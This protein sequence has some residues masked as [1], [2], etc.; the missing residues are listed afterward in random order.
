[1]DCDRCGY[2]V[3]Q[4]A[5]RSR[6]ENVLHKD[7]DIT[8]KTRLVARIECHIRNA[9]YGNIIKPGERCALRIEDV[10]R[11]NRDYTKDQK[12]MKRRDQDRV[13]ARAAARHV[14]QV[15]YEHAIEERR[16]LEAVD[17]AKV[18]AH[19]ARHN[20]GSESV[21]YDP[22]TNVVP[23][24]PSEKGA[25]QS[26]IDRR[27]ETFREARARHIQRSANSAEYDPITGELR[28]FW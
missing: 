10:D 3:Q 23:E 26:A 25:A 1:M 15:D 14:Q 17:V 11:F 19:C 16:R 27:R 9:P 7:R 4:V 22:V 13:L 5:P 2:E 18:M 24:E 8:E 20:L 6:R 28:A 12:A 21:L